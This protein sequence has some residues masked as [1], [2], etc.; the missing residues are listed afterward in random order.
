MDGRWQCSCWAWFL[1]VLAVVAGDTVSTG[2]T[3]EV[4]PGPREQD[5]H[6]HVQA[7]PALQSADDYVHISSK[8]CDLH[9]TTVDGQRQLMVPARDGTSCKLTDLRGVCVSGKCEP[10]GCDGVLFST[11]TLDKCGVCQGDGSSCTHVTGNYRK[12]NAHLG[13]SLVTHIPAGARDIQI[14]ERKKSADVLA[15]ADEAGYYFFNGNYKVDSPKNFNI[16]GTVVKYRRPMDVYETG[17]EYIVAQG[18]TNQGLNVMVWNQNGK[19]PS[20]TFEY[21]LLQPPHES[22]PQPIYYGFSEPASESAESQGLDGAGLMGFV[23]HNGSLYGQASSERLGLDNRLFGHPG[24][25]MELGQSQGQ[26][27]NEVCEQAGG[28]A[29]EGPPRGKGFRDHNV[30]GTPLTG[31]KDDEEVDTHFAS[32]EFFSANAI[33]DQLLGAGSDLKD[34]T[35]NETVN[36]IFAQ[37]APRSSLAESFFVDYEENEGAGPYLL[38]G[39]YLEL[40]SDRVANSSSEAPFPNVSTSLPTS[41]GNRT[42]KART[43][44]KARKQGVS[45][46]DMYRWK[47]SS[48][49]PCSA[50]CTTGVMSAYAMC[51]RYDGVEVD[52]SYCDALTRPEPVHEFCA[53]REC[54]PRWETSSWSECSR[55]CGEGYQFRV[56]RC[57][58]MLSPGF[59]S[60]VYSDLCEAAEA[61]RPE[62]RKTCRNPAC[63]PQWEMSEWS[64]CT[65]KCGER[66]VVTRDIRCSEDEKLCDPN[67]RPVGEKNCTGPPC[68]RQW[69]VSDW[70]PCSGS[71]GQ[72]RTIRHVY[73]K[74]SDGRVVPE[75]QCQMETKPLAIHPCGDKN[76]PAHWLAQDWERCNTT[77]G[78]GVKKR[79]VLCM[80]LANGKPQT[81]SGPEC[82]LAKKPPEESTCFERPCFKWYTSPW[83]ECTKTCGVGVRMRDVKCYQGT[84]IV[85]G[86]DPLVKPVGR[87]ACDLQPCPTEPPDDSC[88]DQPG[89]NCALAIK[90]N[91][92][93]HWYYSKA[94]CRSCRPPHS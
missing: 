45:P 4:R 50:T 84:D 76:C 64:E 65:A 68:D 30:T 49:E 43:R 42:H 21:T 35:L 9:C 17:I 74:T 39:S 29:C 61:V 41:A 10:I 72:G 15:L 63:G 59:D 78:R 55:T 14:V 54:Q 18:P 16:A 2:S 6:G 46:A 73:C 20:I 48:H 23:P 7:V 57:W 69:T 22:R 53:G 91:L 86:C 60:S 79:L 24:L 28:G 83:S 40:S 71:C 11:H 58:K 87:Q 77:C 93:G 89:T 1:L 92:C 12:G 13:Y 44:P 62:E 85:R 34:F 47:L 37:G 26:E 52:D 67:T 90:V 88:Q 51:V 25:D 33:S 66:S 75:S 5:L 36:S 81:R 31:D 56:V 27:T 70:G 38:N 94:C 32:Q 80:E 3:E 8:P 82:G 19:S